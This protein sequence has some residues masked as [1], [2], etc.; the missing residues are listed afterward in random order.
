MEE[1]TNLREETFRNLNNGEVKFKDLFKR[2]II[3]VM[4]VEGGIICSSEYLRQMLTIVSNINTYKVLSI[5]ASIIT[6]ISI[7]LIFVTKENRMIH[8]IISKTKVIEIKNA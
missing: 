2:E 6:F 3:G 4:L 8:D 7:I 1:W 5:L